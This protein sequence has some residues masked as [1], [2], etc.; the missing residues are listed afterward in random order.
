[1]RA[2]VAVEGRKDELLEELAHAGARVIEHRDRLILTENGPKHAA[3]ASNVWYRPER[4]SVASIREA[5]EVLSARAPRWCLLS[6][7]HHRR[8]ALIQAGLHGPKVT[9]LAFGTSP[10]RETLGSWTLLDEHTL[11][12]SPRCASSFPNGEIEFVEDKHAPP[13]RAYLKL[14]EAFTV[15]GRKPRKGECCLDLGSSPGGWTWVLASLGAKVKSVDKAPLD[16]KVAG[17]SGV[18]FE[19]CS[20]FALDPAEHA[21]VDWLFSDVICY[22]ERLYETVQRWIDAGKAKHFVCTLKFQGTTDH[23]TARRFAKIPGS[24]LMHLH[25]NRHELTWCRFGT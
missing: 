6:Q 22:P 4:I 16:P 24:R 14:W 18:H 8:A 10:P 25:H 5:T 1:M 2:Y 20:A 17:M 21:P 23:D 7:V 19:Q 3:W 13:S 15:T 12:A 9:P 11:I